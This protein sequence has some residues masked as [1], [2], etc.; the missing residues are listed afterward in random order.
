[1]GTSPRL[2]LRANDHLDSD[3]RNI[4][5]FTEENNYDYLDDGEHG[6]E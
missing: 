1:M 3:G 5:Q 4:G 2:G 6:D